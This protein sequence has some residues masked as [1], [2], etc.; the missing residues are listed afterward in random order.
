M[1]ALLAKQGLTKNPSSTPSEYAGR[2]ASVLG[3]D[4]ADVNSTVEMVTAGFIEARYSGRVIP[5]DVTV[6]AGLAIQSLRVKLK[7]ARAEKRLPGRRELR[8]KWQAK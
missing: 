3:E 4:M 1:C 5:E 8:N 6:S 7:A 2:V